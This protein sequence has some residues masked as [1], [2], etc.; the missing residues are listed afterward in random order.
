M[1]GIRAISLVLALAVTGM[2]T[3]A[4]AVTVGSQ[5]GSD[6]GI[7][8]ILSSAQTSGQ[9]LSLTHTYSM[10]MLS[11]ITSAV[12]AID[13]YRPGS[14]PVAP[15]SLFFDEQ[16]LDDFGNGV[17]SGYVLHTFDLI[18]E[19]LGSYLDGSNTIRLATNGS[20]FSVDYSSLSI[21]GNLISNP[22]PGTAILLGSGLIG[23]ASYG[24]K[25]R[26][27]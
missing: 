11:G 1:N 13:I 20:E 26:K 5:N 2:A 15:I 18:S 19:G 24:R 10:A 7:Y 16:L 14:T 6:D 4:S 25:R 21:E 12:L 8:D 17:T 27:V 9:S 23:L 22:E 3:F